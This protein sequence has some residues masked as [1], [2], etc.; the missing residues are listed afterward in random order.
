VPFSG[1][2]SPVALSRCRPP[3]MASRERRCDLPVRDQASPAAGPGGRGDGCLGNNPT[4]RR[5]GSKPIYRRS[6]AYRRSGPGARPLAHIR[7]SIAPR[8]R[9]GVERA[10]IS[11]T[12][13]ACYERAPAHG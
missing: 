5:G 4:C 2:K 1:G 11:G 7:H 3:P 6:H 13:A 10:M 12:L 8:Q 9:P